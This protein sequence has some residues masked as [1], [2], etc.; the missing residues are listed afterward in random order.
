[1][2]VIDKPVAAAALEG[3]DPHIGLLGSAGLRPSGLAVVDASYIF[4]RAAARLRRAIAPEGES[5][6]R[7]GSVRLFA[8]A[9]TARELA[10][11]VDLAARRLHVSGADMRRVIAGD[12]VPRIRFVNLPSSNDLADG[13]LKTLFDMDPDDIDLGR[14]GLLL[15]PCHV[16]SHDKHLRIAGFSLSVEELDSVLAAGLQ[17]ELG[18]GAIVTSGYAVRAGALGVSGAVRGIAVRLEV[19]I[20][21]VAL[22]GAL[23]V[24]GGVWWTLSNPER[25]AKAED[26]F[27]KLAV[28]AGDVAARR[29]AGQQLLESTS[30]RP[31]VTSVE[32]RIF[33]ALAFSG[34][35]LLASE[36]HAA[37][38][39]DGE[40]PTPGWIRTFMASHPA[41]VRVG[42]HRWQLGRQL[43]AAPA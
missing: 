9:R 20:W 24:A 15:A 38:A 23:L 27:K 14:L 37:M 25:K 1:M 8:P 28:S 42:A 33:R 29:L 18:D 19:P 26:L 7:V 6:G 10:L 35:P 36:I 3:F 31:T 21:V 11:N 13:R 39:T 17:I 41:F 2:R 22:A 16:Y 43:A 12:L 4:D 5:F 32:S 30:V 34:G 40:A